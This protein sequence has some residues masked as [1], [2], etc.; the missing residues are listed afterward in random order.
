M[1][2]ACEPHSR[3]KTQTKQVWGHSEHLCPGTPAP[4][5]AV[6]VTE[7]WSHVRCGSS[8]GGLTDLLLKESPQVAHLSRLR[9]HVL[10]TYPAGLEL[11]S[12]SL[13]CLCLCLCLGPGGGHIQVLSSK[14]GRLWRRVCSPQSSSGCARFALLTFLA[15]CPAS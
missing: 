1:R 10:L 15:L 2:P 8:G 4:H 11:L 6:G 14:A 9:P 3:L 5:R 13:L 12:G 7:W